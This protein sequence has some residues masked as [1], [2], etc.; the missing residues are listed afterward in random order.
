MIERWMNASAEHTRIVRGAVGCPPVV[1]ADQV[2]AVPVEGDDPLR[3]VGIIRQL[4][5][6]GAIANG[7][8]RTPLDCRPAREADPI[9]LTG[10]TGPVGS[11]AFASDGRLASASWDYTARIWSAPRILADLVDLARMCTLRPLGTVD[12][13]GAMLPFAIA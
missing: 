11:V 12:R 10:H 3:V 4:L 8:S 5:T 7:R 1:A 9:T 6:S 13:Q 2:I